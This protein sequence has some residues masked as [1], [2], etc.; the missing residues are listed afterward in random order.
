MLQKPN[1]RDWFGYVVGLIL[2]A[3]GTAL[4]AKS[5]MGTA[6][7]SSL[8]YVVSRKFLFFSFGVWTYVVQGL[9]MLSMIA[10]VRKVKVDY[11]A[12]FLTSVA[13]GYMIDFFIFCIRALPTDTLALRILYYLMGYLILTCGVGALML[14]RLPI[15]PFDMFL[16]EVSYY[17]NM[18]IQSVKL[19]FDVVVLSVGLILS[20]ALYGSLEGIGVGTFFAALSNGPTIQWMRKRWLRILDSIPIMRDSQAKM[21]PA[22]DNL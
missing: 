18:S 21:P 2:V 20:I 22:A 17:K 4:Y 14:T 11:L 12:S 6:V 15:A 13:A 9:T 3:F 7:G 1:L 16:R 8:A 5:A 10:I 19:R